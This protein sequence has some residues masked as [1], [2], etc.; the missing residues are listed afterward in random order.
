MLLLANQS[1][2]FHVMCWNLL[3]KSA[4]GLN[5]T[6]TEKSFLPK[7][8]RNWTELNITANSDKIIWYILNWIAYLLMLYLFAYTNM[9]QIDRMRRPPWIDFIKKL[10]LPDSFENLSNQL[11]IQHIKSP[12][13]SLKVKLPRKTL[14]WVIV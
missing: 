14:L 4:P 2:I 6:L 12:F 10:S 9:L 13:K 8:K 5:P 3:M 1:T 11:I 7:N